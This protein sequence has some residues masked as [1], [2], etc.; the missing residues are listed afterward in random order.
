MF[1][2]KEKVEKLRLLSVR[3]RQIYNYYTSLFIDERLGLLEQH[4]GSF[5]CIGSS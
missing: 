4:G 1:T 3:A 2:T 5:F